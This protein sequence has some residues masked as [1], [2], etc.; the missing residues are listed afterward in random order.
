MVVT[1]H[2]AGGSIE[3]HEILADLSRLSS[4]LSKITG[5]DCGG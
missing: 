4:C 2:R 5:V 3:N 1:E